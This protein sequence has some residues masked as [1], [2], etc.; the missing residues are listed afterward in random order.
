MMKHEN[1]VFDLCTYIIEVHTII[2]ICQ[3]S[4]I[5][6]NTILKCVNNPICYICKH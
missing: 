6:H 2:K 3:T 5:K 4:V 1:L